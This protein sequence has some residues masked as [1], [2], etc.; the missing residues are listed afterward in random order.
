MGNDI[1]LKVIFVLDIGHIG[2]S[3]QL[4]AQG[5]KLSDFRGNYLE[6]AAYSN[7]IR[8]IPDNYLH[9]L[10]MKIPFLLLIPV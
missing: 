6:L 8:L 1:G 7:T 9:G 4:A 5:C 10:K 2:L 3:A